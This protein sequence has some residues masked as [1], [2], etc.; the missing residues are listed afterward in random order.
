ME[1]ALGRPVILC[2]PLRG[3]VCLYYIFVYACI[4]ELR[5]Y[6]FFLFVEHSGLNHTPA[7]RGCLYKL[8]AG[9]NNQ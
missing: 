9:P 5:L 2:K 6:V 8:F 4:L 3:M 7:L 1:A